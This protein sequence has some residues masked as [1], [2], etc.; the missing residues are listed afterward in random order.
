MVNDKNQPYLTSFLVEVALGV[1]QELL[2][3]GKYHSQ[4]VLPVV[5]I[6]YDHLVVFREAEIQGIEYDLYDKGTID[7]GLAF[8]VQGP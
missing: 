7:L 2:R 4:L 3:T 1:F 5:I 6:A 8:I